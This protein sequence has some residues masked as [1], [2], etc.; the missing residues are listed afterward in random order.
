[1][2]A[3]MLLV[4]GL[5]AA[6]LTSNNSFAAVIFPVNINIADVAGEGE[7]PEPGRGGT[8][9]V[10]SAEAT[11][12]NLEKGPGE[13]LRFTVDVGFN[14]NQSLISV[15]LCEPF[16]PCT[17][18][19]QG[20]VV[21]A[22]DVILSQAIAPTVIRVTF[23]SDPDAF[24]INRP[25][26]TFFETGDFQPVIRY[27]DIFGGMG[28]AIIFVASEVSEPTPEPATVILFSLGL[29]GLGAFLWRHHRS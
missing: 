21:G 26:E 10:A 13:Q 27:T 14:V 23:Q 17:L 5:I 18:D 8:P 24:L 25:T 15:V 11:I 12:M 28:E 29:F 9:A 7:E 2:K 19:S 6:L 22:S 4:L 1:M 3:Q 20:N 16:Q